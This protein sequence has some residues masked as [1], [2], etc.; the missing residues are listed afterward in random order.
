MKKLLLGAALGLSLM[1]G[2]SM[3]NAVEFNAKGEW[4]FGFG[5]VDASFFK[6]D[7]GHNGGD[8]FKAQQRIRLYL[9]A[10][11]SETLSATLGIEIG[12]TTW[13]QAS[14]DGDAM[15]GALGTDGVIVGVR[16]AYLDWTVPDSRLMFR[17]GLQGV[18]LPNAAGGSA[19]LDD[20]TAAIVASWQATETVGITAFWLRPVNDNYTTGDPNDP[21]V[22]FN[23]DD[24]NNYLDNID[25][26]GISVP[27]VTESMEITP[28]AMIGIM[29][30]N[31]YDD[32]GAF[33]TPLSYGNAQNE[34]LRAARAYAKQYYVGLPIAISAIAPF[35]IELDLNYGYAEG[36]GNYTVTDRYGANRR[37][38]TERSGWLI[39]A[40]VEYQMEWGTPGILGWYASGDD[41]NAKNGSERMPSISPAGNFTS[42]MQDGD[43]YSIDTG[44][45]LMLSYGGTWGLGLQ[46]KDL[47]FMNNISHTLRAVY[48]G[49]T[50]SASAIKYTNNG[51]SWVE[52]DGIIY[53]TTD[54]HLIEFNVDTTINIYDNLTA[55][56]ELGYIVN[57]VD[58]GAWRRNLIAN[59]GPQTEDAWKAAV[60]MKYDF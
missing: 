50:N 2:P 4:Y 47:S 17:M 21:G 20:Q 12:D 1:A 42:F 8:I 39:K 57:G 23:D 28:W 45:D 55:I 32:L 37:V 56:V 40:L 19:V 3:A 29:G 24:P 18:T 51:M 15:G 46:L 35:N 59:R 58:D 14:A 48:W 36:I 30:K 54:D 26:F 5:G 33:S 7:D 11:M 53:L 60:L 31:A 9:D 41:G 49:G 22:R 44:Y 52:D 16:D 6:N 34:S 38:S 43:G 25:Y 13:G 27:I 10:T